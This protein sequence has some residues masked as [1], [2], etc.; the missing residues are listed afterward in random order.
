M[1]KFHNIRTKA[2]LCFE[3]ESYH[4]RKQ[5]DFLSLLFFC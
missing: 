4:T 3:I 5:L 2:A 1:I